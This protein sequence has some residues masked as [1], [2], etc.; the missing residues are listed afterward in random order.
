LTCIFFQS[1]SQEISCKHCISGPAICPSRD[2]LFISDSDI[3]ELPTFTP[4]T[5][6]IDSYPE[7]GIQ[8]AYSGMVDD[9]QLICGG[10]GADGSL[11]SSC[12]SLQD[13]GWSKEADNDL[14]RSGAAASMTPGGLM[15][16]GGYGKGGYLSSTEIFKENVWVT[17]PSLPVGVEG[18]CQ[19]QIG[20]HV[21]VVGGYP[22]PS[23]SGATYSLDGDSW[24]SLGELN[25]PRGW[26]ACSHQDN[27]LYV[28]G[29][30]NGASGNVTSTEVLD[31]ETGTWRSG[32]DLPY[33][34][35]DGKAV[36]YDGE[37]YLVGG[38]GSDGIIVKLNN[39]RDAWEEVGNTGVTGTRTWAP[40]PVVSSEM[41]D[42]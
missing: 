41:F 32:P 9:R 8:Y 37:L 21:I 30:Y 28:M 15:V 35:Y 13:I 25:T 6:T 27:E 12:Y 2:L 7:R 42:C 5:C 31:L 1:T 34:A 14:A 26:H 22:G 10:R 20:D 23:P 38:F 36:H 11:L 16:T 29:G 18:H 17:G 4:S 3:L 40:A 19:V 33:P 39:E 24:I